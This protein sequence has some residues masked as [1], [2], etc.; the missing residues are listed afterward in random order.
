MADDDSDEVTGDRAYAL[1]LSG[2]SARVVAKQ[3]N[4]TIAQVHSAVEARLPTIDNAYRA[5]MM[6][7][8]CER[9][10]RIVGKFYGLALQGDPQAAMCLKHFLG[11]RASVLGF[12]APLRVDAVSLVALAAPQETSTERYKRLLDLLDGT[13]EAGNGTESGTGTEIE[14]EAPKRLQ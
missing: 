4:I 5:R 10:E 6:A 8:D 1:R 9:I 7:M 13:S 11:R 12:D 2:A 3:L 14:I